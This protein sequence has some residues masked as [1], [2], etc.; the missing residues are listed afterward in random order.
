MHEYKPSGVSKD[1]LTAVS[2]VGGDRQSLRTQSNKQFLES[3]TS[4]FNL[5]KF[6][7]HSVKSMAHLQK[8]AKHPQGVHPISKGLQST[9]KEHS[10]IPK[11]CK[12]STRST[13]YLQNIHKEYTQKHPQVHPISKS[14]QSIHKEYIQSPQPRKQRSTPHGC[15]WFSFSSRHDLLWW[16]SHH[17]RSI[18]WRYKPR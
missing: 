14:L 8:S 13:K 17:L 6:Y 10:L 12:A 15:S 4:T 1:S 7:K 2:V 3:R 5:R 16:C 11:V 18:H 9:R